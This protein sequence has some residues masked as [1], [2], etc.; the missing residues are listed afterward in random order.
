MS[1]RLRVTLATVVLAALAVGAADVATFSLLRRYFNDQAD[2]RVHQVA[3]T[4]VTALHRGQRLTLPTFSKTDRPVLVEVRARDGRVLQ[5]LATPESAEVRLPQ[6]LVAHP[7][8]SRQIDAPGHDGAAFRVVALRAGSG[9]TVVVALSLTAEASTLRHLFALN[10]RVGVVVLLLL[11]LVAAVVLTYSLRPLRRIASTAD[12][13]A[14]G[15][16]GERVPAGA[17]RSEIGRVST[18]LNRML[19]EIESAFRERDATESRL[20]QFLADASHELRTPLTSIRGYSELFRRGADRRPE[21]LAHA[22]GAIEQEAERMSQLVDDLL[23]LAR[24]DDARPL[25]RG[26]VALDDLVETAVEAARAVEPGRLFQFEFSERPILVVGDRARLRQVVDNL[27]A[28]IRR[29]TPPGTP[30][31]VT[32]AT[33]GGEATMTVEDAGPGIA[34]AERERIFDRF[35]RTEASRSRVAG[36][37]GL[38]LAIVRSIVVA[39]GGRIDLRQARPHGAIFEVRLPRASRAGGNDAFSANSQVTPSGDSHAS[40]FLGRRHSAATPKETL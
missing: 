30:A 7:G 29:H 31:Y 15:N 27:F 13:I 34:D 8:R 18:A 17:R 11:A 38:G 22:M 23:L 10:F 16:L 6:G 21:D 36:G 26:P 1:I 28:N 2:G 19:G 9:R 37:A 25:E 5:R 35:F 32:V 14:A 3:Q 20:R 33:D 40:A 24:L 39:H 4:A 12:S